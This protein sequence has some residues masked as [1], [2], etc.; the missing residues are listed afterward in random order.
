MAEPA[1]NQLIQICP[2]D[3]PPFLDII[4][5]YRKAAHHLGLG[6]ADYFLSPSMRQTAF[7][8]GRE[9]AVRHPL[10][11]RKD[12]ERSPERGHPALEDARTESVPLRSSAANT[13]SRVDAHYLDCDDL[14]NT[15][16]LA[17]RLRQALPETGHSLVL[18]HRYRAYKSF[19]ATGLDA[20]RLVAVAHEYGFFRRR[21]RR[22]ARRLSRRNALFAGVSPGVAEELK[23]ATGSALV[24]PNALDLDVLDPLDR[25]A[26]RRALALPPEGLV[27]GVVGRLHYK[28]RPELALEAFRLFLERTGESNA[29]LAFVGDG[30]LRKRLEL[31]SRDLPVTFAG[32]MPAAARLMKAFDALLMASSNEPFGMV[33]LEAMAADVPVV[34]PRQAGPLCILA[35]LGHYFDGSEPQAIAAA[36]Q[37]ALDAPPGEGRERARREFSV[38]VVA[39]RLQGLRSEF[40]V[41][42]LGRE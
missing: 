11:P 15:A 8:R 35:D 21:R 31:A 40:P 23:Q 20:A 41:S 33:L 42:A 4:G 1:F 39:Q 13:P 36:L 34:A 9:P 2:N 22:W 18:C 29:R 7:N 19:V 28:K 37:A 26:A 14:K 27:F 25:A 24:W 38:N 32:F 30:A 5:V 12:V 17:R 16:A 10:A 6:G 3:G